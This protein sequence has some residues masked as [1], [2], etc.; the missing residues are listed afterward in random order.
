MAPTAAT[1]SISVYQYDSKNSV[2][3]TSHETEFGAITWRGRDENE[4]HLLNKSTFC[5]G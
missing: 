2:M 1:K 4:L 3:Q 5:M